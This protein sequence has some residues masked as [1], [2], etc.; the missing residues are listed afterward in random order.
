M[1]R[2]IPEFWP[3][4]GRIQ[5][6]QTY[7]YTDL[8]SYGV[9]RQDSMRVRDLCRICLVALGLCIAWVSAVQLAL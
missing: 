2:R 1:R 8:R 3:A 5:A 7:L 6:G 4:R 9:G